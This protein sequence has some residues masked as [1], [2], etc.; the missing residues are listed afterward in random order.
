MKIREVRFQSIRG[1][2]SSS[3]R[4][5]LYDEQTKLVRPLSVIVGSN[6]SGKSTLFHIIE[7]L[8][9][10][11][12]EI[13]EDRPITKELREEGYAAMS[14]DFGDT[15][16]PELR[17]EL[18]IALGRKDRAPE[19]HKELPNQICRLEMRGGHGRAFERKGP[20]RILNQWVGDMVRD[21]TAM[22]DGILFFP[23]NRWIEHEQRGAIEVPLRS[24]GKRRSTSAAR[25]K[26]PTAAAWTL[27]PSTIR[28]IGSMLGS[29]ATES[30]TKSI[31]MR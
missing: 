3:R 29:L 15:A 19:D 26:P 13:V 9:S 11:A 21:R 16:P 6:G 27:P 2:G 7:G 20:Q 5:A 28:C 30:R 4:I 8:F 31:L 24:V 10:Y 12:L 22:R 1:F 18:W 25:S 23:H 17:N 14:V